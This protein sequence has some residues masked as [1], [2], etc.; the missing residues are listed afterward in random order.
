[1]DIPIA[2]VLCVR[3]LQNCNES[4]TTPP[5]RMR[6]LLGMEDDS[7]T[8]GTDGDTILTGGKRTMAFENFTSK[9]AA[10][11]ASNLTGQQSLS[12]DVWNEM[13]SQ[14]GLANDSSSTVNT[15]QDIWQFSADDAKALYGEDI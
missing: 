12:Q 2:S 5:R 10:A 4:V 8:S 9:D 11:E 13:P 15:S 7:D 1:M 3:R 14:L 6:I